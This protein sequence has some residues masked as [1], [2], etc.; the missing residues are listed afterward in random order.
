MLTPAIISEAFSVLAERHD[1]GLSKGGIHSSLYHQA[2]WSAILQVVGSNGSRSILDIG[3][4]NGIWTVPLALSGHKVVY[5]DVAE[6]MAHITRINLL[7][8]G[9]KAHVIVGDA[10]NLDFLPPNYFD[11]VL[12]VGD[13]LCYSKLPGEICQQAY[14]RCK[15]G[16]KMVVSV[17]GRLGVIQHLINYL[18]VE[19]VKEY[20][21]YGWWIEFTHDELDIDTPLV[22]HTYTVD[23]LRRLCLSAGW[24]ISSFFGAGILRTLI[25]RESLAR[26]IDREG[27]EAVLSLE[28]ELTK[29]PALLECAM[30]FGMIIEKPKVGFRA[31]AS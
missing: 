26:F 21:S 18:S 9:G 16:G 12:A 30:E 31:L 6:K 20:I 10:H 19:Q 7:K 3:G 4:G 1:K 17:M 2:I 8:S 11:V 28:K 24:Q 13:L 23:E 29:N 25:G 27:I 14:K 22:A 15:P 5:V